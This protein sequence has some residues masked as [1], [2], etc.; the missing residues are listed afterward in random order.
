MTSILVAGL[1]E[2]GKTTFLAAL[3]HLVSSREMDTTLRFHSLRDGDYTHLNRLSSK[4]RDAKAQE[5]TEMGSSPITILSLKNA[6]DEA[7]SVAFP[8]I[9]GEMFGRIWEDRECDST[10]KSLAQA[11]ARVALFIHANTITAPH[12]IVEQV[13]MMN[14]LE[15]PVEEEDIP[16]VA[17]KSPTQVKLVELLQALLSERV[18]ADPSRLIIV[19][20]AWD[21]VRA[22]GLSP[23]E[24]LAS[25]LP[26]LKQYLDQM[27]AAEW[28]V[29]GVSALGGRLPDDASR[30]L[31]EE[32]P[33]NRILVVVD[34]GESNDLTEPIS[35]LME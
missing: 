3:W 9:S 6:S 26:L 11:G 23:T 18:G 4:W 1:P 24:F 16:W 17:A 35:W 20:S 13:A 22:E 28:R 5:R 19:F 12:W 10:I 33:S 7:V 34:E 15:L 30:L 14:E 32:I 21:M 29:Y 27:A 8:D 2:S 25:H 31:Q